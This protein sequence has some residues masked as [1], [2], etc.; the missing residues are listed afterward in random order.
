[1]PIGKKSG[2]GKGWQKYLQSNAVKAGLAG[3]V[4]LLLVLVIGWQ[5]MFG[6]GSGTKSIGIPASSDS[7]QAQSATPSHQMPAETAQASPDQKDTSVNQNAQTGQENKQGQSTETQP[8]PAQPEQQ[9]P[10]TGAHDANQETVPGAENSSAQLKLPEDIYKWEKAD[11]IRA[12]QENNP[13]LLEGVAYLGEKFPGSVPKAQDLADLLKTPKPADSSTT[14]YSPNVVP[15]LIEVTINALGKNGSEAAQNTLIQILNGKLTTDD[16]RMAVEAV[17]KTLIQTPSAEND[18]IL[19]KVIITPEEFRPASSQGT[20]Q[21]SELRSQVLDLVKDK[22]SEDLNIKLAKK[23]VQRGLEPNDPVVDFLLQDNPVNLNAQLHLYQSEDLSADTKTRL[24][25]YFLNHS[26]QAIALMM[27]IPTGVEGAVSIMPSVD[28]RRNQPVG[29]DPRTIHPGGRERTPSTGPVET[30]TGVT[31]GDAAKSKISDYER[32]AYLAKLLWGEPLAGLM[33]QHL[34]DVHSLE[35]SA[36]DIMLASTLPLD[37]IHAAMFKMLKKRAGDGPQ[38]LEAAGWN[39]KVLTDP[40]LLVIMK[41]LPRSKTLKTASISGTTSAA[42]PTRTGRYPTTRRP[43]GADTGGT[44]VQPTRTE[45]AQ[46]KEQIESEWLTTLSKM[47]DTW[48]NRFADAAQAQKKAERRGQKVLEQRPTRLDEFEIP[49]DAKN[50]KDVKIIAAYQLNWPDKAPGDLG[51]VKLAGLKIQYFRF[52][53]TGMLKKT[54]IA[55]KQLAKGGDVHDMSN[56][57]WLEMIKNGSQPG[58]KRSLD[59]LVTSADKQQVD[60][61]QKIEESIDLEVDILAI[62]ITDPGAVKE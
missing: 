28:P 60:L 8:E 35:K 18:D 3:V 11:F 42:A 39:D 48:C 29:V 1:M 23:L 24:E 2:K 36:P 15:G 21:A 32:G 54:M 7:N 26:S 4:V 37:S 22:P 9:Q 59:I 55:L 13:K 25:Q 57:Q 44:G 43:P 41:L 5:L 61:T 47:V 12:R 17:L 27:G 6:G 58:T 62:E 50:L 53:L 52:Q 20:L 46:K 49:Q 45:A 38:P 10:R 40:G 34:S 51:K 33:T 30:N 16:D 19:V 56:G 31:A 14:P